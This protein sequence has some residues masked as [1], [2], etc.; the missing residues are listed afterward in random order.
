[1]AFFKGFGSL[2]VR[3]QALVVCGPSGEMMV[4]WGA[5]CIF[6]FTKFKNEKYFLKLKILFVLFYFLLYQ[7][8]FIF[9]VNV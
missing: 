6:P 2:G 9:W 7:P 5:K 8:L 3:V 4:V 1:L